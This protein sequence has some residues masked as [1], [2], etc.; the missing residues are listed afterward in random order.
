MKQAYTKYFSHF[1]GVWPLLDTLMSFLPFWPLCW[2]FWEWRGYIWAILPLGV[3]LGS[4]WEYLG[5]L[6]C[7]GAQ[8]WQKTRIIK[9]KL[10]KIHKI[11]PI[12]MIIKEDINKKHQNTFLSFSIIESRPPNQILIYSIQIRPISSTYSGFHN[13][14]PH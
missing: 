9:K 6:G 7:F 3:H 1:V 11:D 10:S 12:C 8:N 4:F 5:H 14:S 2:V 13:S